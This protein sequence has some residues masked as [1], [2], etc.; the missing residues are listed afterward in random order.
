MRLPMVGRWAGWG[1]GG[2]RRGETGVRRCEPSVCLRF[3]AVSRE[4]SGWERRDESP[5]A[6]GKPLPASPPLAHLG[7]WLL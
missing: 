3:T 1:R 4:R 2:E 7:R 6:T 5:P